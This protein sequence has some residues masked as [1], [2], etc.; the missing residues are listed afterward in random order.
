MNKQTPEW[1][2]KPVHWEDDE[3]HYISFIFSWDL[4]KWCQ[5]AQPLLNEK[6][7]VV[8]GP[9]VILNSEWV[10]E[11]VKIG[12]SREDVYDRHYFTVTR[13]T[14]GCIRKCPFCAVPTIEG[15]FRELKKW[16]NK[17]VLIDNNL[18][19]S[20]R[21]HFAR[22]IDSLKKLTWCDFSQGLD[23]RLMKKWHAEKLSELKFAK[24][25]LAWDYTRYETSFFR[26][27][28]LLEKE[29]IPKKRITTYV[30]I[31]FD[32]DPE[33]ALYRL[34]TI[35]GKGYTTFPMRYQPLNSK[36]K[37]EYIHQN[38]TEKELCR[39]MKYWSSHR[40]FAGI[41]FEEFDYNKYR[42]SICQQ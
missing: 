34:R 16:E 42:R 18:L 41:P 25:R 33:D 1:R 2:K 31:G 10:P 3:N 39:Y 40:F 27:C 38:W 28:E 30:L 22:V 17:P 5:T 11:W 20:S 9:A 15:Q 24:I 13:T 35:S 12:K 4:W 26:A 29:G 37:N 14:R 36:E 7:I 8:G 23:S 32:D 21:K 19:A 6:Q